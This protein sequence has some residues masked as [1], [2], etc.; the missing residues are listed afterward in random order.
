M[1]L[2]TDPILPADPA[3]LVNAI[4]TLFRR[5]ATTVNGMAE[6]RLS[7]VDSFSAAPTAGTWAQ[8]DM[9]RNSSPVEL[10][11]AGS[12]YVIFGWLAVAGGTP[13][14]WVQMRNLTGN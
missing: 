3:G 8:G 14:T 2:Q 13:G 4:K 12:K 9:V 1:K 11:T 6:G 5:T 7:A 10:G